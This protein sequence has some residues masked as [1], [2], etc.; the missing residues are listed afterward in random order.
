M[1]SKK[2]IHDNP[3]ST[4]PTTGRKDRSSLSLLTLLAGVVFLCAI[5]CPSQ[6]SQKN[7]SGD[8]AKKVG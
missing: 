5:G 4:P 3:G 7:R 1:E 6:S 2:I 8:A